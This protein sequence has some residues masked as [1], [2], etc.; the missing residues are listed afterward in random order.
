MDQL[1]NAME[2]AL[3]DLGER[4]PK[5][6]ME[7]QVKISEEIGEL[8]A[9]VLHSQGLK[10]LDVADPREHVLEEG[11][12]VIIMALSILSRFNFQLPDVEKMMDQK[13]AK[14]E[15]QIEKAGR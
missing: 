9:A 8:A 13:M 3:N 5:T 15:R 6:L 14:W 10:K 7:L 4:E 12:D 2:R 1:I 11:C